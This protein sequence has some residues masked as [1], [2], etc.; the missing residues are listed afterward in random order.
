MLSELEFARVLDIIAQGRHAERNRMALMLSF[1]GGLRACEIAALT[2]GT[3][4]GARGDPKDQIH[5][6]PRMTKGNRGRTIVVSG[7]LREEIANYVASLR[8]RRP[9]NPFLRS[10]KSGRGFSPNTLVQLFGRIYSK[11]GIEASSHSGR[12]SF[13]STLAAKGVSVR[14]LQTLAGHASIATTQRYIDVNDHM[15]RSAVEML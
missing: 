12:R 9:E 5:L 4:I 11:A 3:V 14:V 8:D 6:L 13:I 1:L 7:R 15:L 2:V 10:Q